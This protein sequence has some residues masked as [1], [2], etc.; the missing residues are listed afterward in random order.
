MSTETSSM[1]VVE[2]GIP[3]IRVVPLDQQVCLMGGSPDADVFVDN[4]F[5]HECTL[6]S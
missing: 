1:L 6:R 5:I 4:P 2:R 3:G